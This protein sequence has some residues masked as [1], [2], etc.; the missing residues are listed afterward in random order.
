MNPEFT[1]T[2][3]KVFFL[4]SHCDLCKDDDRMLLASIWEAELQGSTNVIEGLKSGKL[5]NPETVTRIRRKLQEKSPNLRGAKWD[6]RHN[7][8]A[9]ICQQ[10]TFFNTWGN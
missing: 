3:H 8:E 6:V 4:L 10:L 7:M 5:S 9:V 2:A 1:N